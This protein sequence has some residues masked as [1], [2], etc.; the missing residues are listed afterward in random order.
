MYL[1]VFLQVKYLSNFARGVQLALSLTFYNRVF[2][3][4]KLDSI[5]FER[6]LKR[7]I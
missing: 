1:F 2:A 6:I 5:T 4:L 3:H 7:F